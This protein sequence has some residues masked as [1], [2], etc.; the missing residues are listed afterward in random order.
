M[1]NIFQIHKY[2]QQHISKT[3]ISC[4]FLLQKLFKTYAQLCAKFNFDENPGEKQGAIWMKHSVVDFTG[5]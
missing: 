2:I 4:R 5:I 3:F 1:P